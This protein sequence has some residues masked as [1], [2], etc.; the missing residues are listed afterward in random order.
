[1]IVVSGSFGRGK[2]QKAFEEAAF[3]LKV[4][5]ISDV[6]DSESG[7]HIIKRTG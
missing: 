7:A 1:M 2:L 6:V 3:A 5:D 4:G